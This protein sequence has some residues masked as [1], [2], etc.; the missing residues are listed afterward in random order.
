MSDSSDPYDNAYWI[1][2]T[3][4]VRPAGMKQTQ[5]VSIDIESFR[6]ASGAIDVVAAELGCEL[7]MNYYLVYSH[8]KVSETEALHNTFPDKDTTYY[9]HIENIVTGK[10][11]CVA[12]ACAKLHALIGNHADASRLTTLVEKYGDHAHHTA[13]ALREVELHDAAHSAM[14]E[15]LAAIRSQISDHAADGANDWG[16]VV[17]APWG[18]AYV[19]AQQPSSAMPQPQCPTM[20]FYDLAGPGHWRWMVD[21]LARRRHAR[22]LLA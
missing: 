18:P 17:H 15:E 16:P 1:N 22:V 3:V 2:M 19:R 5:M 14:E 4:A 6:S 12:Q 20:R 21:V 11:I 8:K 9:C 7:G 10:H 13:K